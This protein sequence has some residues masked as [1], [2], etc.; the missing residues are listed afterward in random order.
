MKIIQWIL[1]LAEAEFLISIMV[2]LPTVFTSFL[3]GGFLPQRGT[4]QIYNLF[5]CQKYPERGLEPPFYTFFDQKTGIGW[6][7]NTIFSS[8]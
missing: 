3:V 1:K 6:S 8:I 7:K 4:S 2:I 5:L